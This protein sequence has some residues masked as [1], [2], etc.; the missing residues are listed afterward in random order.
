MKKVMQTVTDPETGERKGV[1]VTKQHRLSGNFGF[2]AFV[3]MSGIGYKRTFTHTV[4]YVRFT[5][6]SGHLVGGR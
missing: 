5:P 2:V 1:E 4:I 6:E 3:V